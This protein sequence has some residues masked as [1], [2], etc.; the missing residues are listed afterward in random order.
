MPKAAQDNY[1]IMEHPIHD[2]DDVDDAFEVAIEHHQAGRM[3]E[4]EALYRRIL[5]LDPEHPGALY[6][7]GGIVYQQG[8]Y[9][10]AFELVEKA[11]Q[12][13]PND[14][15]AL[16]LLGSI[17]Y[18]QQRPALAIELIDR[19]LALHPDYAQAHH[20]R[21]DALL[22]QGEL[23]AAAEG[24]RQA[25]R[26]APQL[27]EA[28]CRLGNVLKLQGRLPEA[29]ASYE[30]ALALQPEQ[31][32]T[33]SSLGELLYLQGQPEAAIVQYR[34]ALALA[35]EHVQTHGLLGNAQHATGDLEGA[36]AS[37]RRAIELQP[38]LALAHNY[39]GAALKALGRVDEAM[40]SYRRAIAIAPE[41]AEAHS[42][43]GVA[44]RD[45]GQLDEAIAC[46]R[47]ALV[48]RPDAA[49]IHANLANTL[50]DRGL[51][52]QAIASYQR[53]IELR[54]EI[55]ELHNYLGRAYKN[56]EQID[57][58]LACYERAVTLKPDYA[59]AYSSFGNAQLKQGRV[60]D[61]IASYRR[62]LELEPMLAEVHSNLGIAL[63]DCGRLDEAIDCFR[64]TV[65]LKPDYI[66]GYT[67][68]LVAAQYSPHYSPA[69][70]LADHR[71]FGDRFGGPWRDRWPQHA[72]R[73]NDRRLRVGFVS[74]DFRE[75]PVGFFLEGT[76]TWLDRAALDIVLYP[77][78]HKVDDLTR[79]LQ[80]LGLPWQP[81]AGLSDDQ[82]AE[83]IAADGI[84]ILVDLS[85]HTADHRLQLFARK[86]APIQVA[87]LGYWATTG[88]QAMDYILG[89][90][91]SIPADEVDHFVEQPWY[92]P[93]TRLCFTPPTDA[94]LPGPLPALANGYITFG[95]FNNL[96]KMTAPVV[97]LW[98]RILHGVPESHLLLKSRA[99]A[100]AP[101]RAAIQRRFAAHGIAAERLLLEEQSSRHDYLLTYNRVDF[102]LD[103]F[104][105]TGATTSVE[106]L[107][108]G[109]PF[110]TLR[111]D[112][113]V[114]H[115]GEGILRNM[116]L[117]DWIA[118]DSDA[119]VAL[120]VARA[121]DRPGLAALRATLRP[122]LLASP[123]CDGPRFARN[124][125]AAFEGMWSRYCAT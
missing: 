87:W 28:H 49:E 16:H 73:R 26:L 15:D 122:R 119:Y 121:N 94:I 27:V 61:A 62:A 92:L 1:K 70:L 113:L 9:E 24:Y 31:A 93:D 52:E 21:A 89:D 71:A 124:L 91:H 56:N 5:E 85:G 60:D 106:G 36:V 114:A 59:E 88:L 42:N 99:L 23:D 110:V 8:D 46:Y 4:A 64:K 51:F 22:A 29:A 35:P 53:A 45:L 100:D 2:L 12:E 98:A 116:G 65:E 10:Q 84:D 40:A 19:A 43:L 101:T 47:S 102:A 123:L 77:T 14:P 112:R 69:Q 107:W 117:A 44:L 39:L 96:T 3:A 67:N 41:Y 103:P 25:L 118:A 82:A 68:Y 115:Q 30:Q 34:Q 111:G 104:P 18:R 66:E 79:R 63:K 32:G 48:H 105:F 97:A 95:C 108:M 57:A 81:L 37:Y 7:L 83:R 75:H 17:A 125:Q 74:G 80:A 38:E 13:E 20:T 33:R 90:P 55:A 11:L 58:A 109:V 86:P 54:P 120:A 6:L 72:P 76:L 50:S 78:V